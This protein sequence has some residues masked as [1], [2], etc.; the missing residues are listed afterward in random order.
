M[1]PREVFQRTLDFENPERVARTFMRNDL[2]DVVGTNPKVKT[3]ATGWQLVGEK[4]WERADEWGNRWRRIDPTSKGEVVKGALETLDAIDS[5]ELPDYSNPEDY[6]RVRAMRGEKPDHY[7]LGWVPGFTFSIARKMR[8]LDQYLMDLV[9]DR[10]R[11]RA[12]HDRIDDMLED[13]I[14]NFARA[15]ADAIAFAEDWGTQSQT[16]ISPDLWRDE[17][18]PRFERLCAAAHEEGAKVIMHSCGAIGAIIPGC[19]EA[20][21]D[22]FQFDQPELHGI[23][24]LAGY[25]ENAKISFW[26]PVDIQRTLQSQDEERIRAAAR[27]MLDK[28]WKGRGGFIAGHYPGEEAIGLEPKWQDIAA[29]EFMKHGRRGPM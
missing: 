7:M 24:T 1:T 2:S 14:R 19:I 25:Q 27:E 5:L 15:G 16:L 20:G 6:E 26:C 28:L 9:L 3:Q 8:K 12:L 4:E 22:C 23:D 13:Y 21:I 17:F 29:D 11:L 10:D 18:F